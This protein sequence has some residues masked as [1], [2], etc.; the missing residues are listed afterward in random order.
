[1]AKKQRIDKILSNLGYGSRSEIKKYCKQGSI[2]VNG[3]EVLNPGTQVDTENDEILFNG[4]EVIY[5][6]YIYLMMNKPDGYISATTDKYDPTVLDLINSS[7]LA[8]EPFPVGRLDKDTEGLLVLTNDG[9]LSHRV[10]SP[11]KHVPKTY[12][13]KIDGV[14][15]EEDVEAFAEGV[16][17]DDGYKTM[18]SQLNI[19]KSDDESEIEL[20]IHEG[21]FHQVKR[22]FESVGKKVVY[23]KRLSM[24]NLKLDESLELG[25]YRELTDEEV[26]LIEER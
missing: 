6:E 21:K 24:G 3:S 19:L 2:V 8:F 26:K 10:L 11:K 17:L 14:V 1:M 23:L 18:P 25:E 22:M 12:Y 15:T 9:K 16:V 4:E 20:T 13:A 7:Y 5:R